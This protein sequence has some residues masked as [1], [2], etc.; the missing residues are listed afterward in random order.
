MSASTVTHCACGEVS[1]APA[2][3]VAYTA[4]QFPPKHH[5][6][7]S[8]FCSCSL[9]SASSCGGVHLFNV[10]GGPCISACCLRSSSASDGVHCTSSRARRQKPVRAT[11]RSGVRQRRGQSY[12][13]RVTDL[14]GCVRGFVRVRDANT[15]CGVYCASACL[16][17]GVTS[18]RVRSASASVGLRQYSPSLWRLLQPCTQHLRQWRLTVRQCMS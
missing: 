5:R 13:P 16:C 8:S 3:V 14:S 12:A 1:S 18:S 10:C 9:R 15:R 6:A 11:L 2:P 17:Y 4:P 7:V